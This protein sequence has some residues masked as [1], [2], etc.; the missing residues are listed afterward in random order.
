[1]DGRPVRGPRRR[2]QLRWSYNKDGSISDGADAA[3][4]DGI[5]LI[6]GDGFLCSPGAVPPD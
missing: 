4:V 6:V 3:R 2:A 5:V 1:M